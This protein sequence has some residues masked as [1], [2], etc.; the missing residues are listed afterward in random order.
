MSGQGKSSIFWT[1]SLFVLFMLVR[2]ASGEVRI[3]H[4]DASGMR[5]VYEGEEPT[6]R[7]VRWAEGT[8][9]IL[10]IAG[11][12]NGAAPGEPALPTRS[13]LLGVP[14][15]GRVE[16]LVTE[17]QA[18]DWVLPEVAPVP[19]MTWNEEGWYEEQF[20]KDEEIYSR[21]AWIPDQVVR[22]ERDGFLRDQRVVTVTFRP[23][24]YNPIRGEARVYRRI[25]AEVRF[26]DERGAVGRA[27]SLGTAPARFERTEDLYRATLLNYEQARSWRRTGTRQAKRARLE[28]PFAPG[29]WFR[30]AVKSDGMYRITGEDL[31]DA[32]ATL[33]DIVPDE[34]RM[35]YG[36]GEELPL[37]VTASRPERMEEMASLVEDGGDGRFDAED[38]IA[39]WG[40]GPSRWD[41]DGAEEAFRYRLN[42]YTH[43]NI[44]WI[45]FGGDLG[46]RMTGRH[47]SSG[48]GEPVRPW[49]F[50]DR[51]HEE[52]EKQ[53]QSTG[54]VKDSGT[55][56]YWEDKV[57]RRYSFLVHSPDEM[58]TTVVRIHMLGLSVDIHRFAIS[59]NDVEIGTAQFAGKEKTGRTMI[60]KYPGGLKDG[61]NLL[62][63]QQEDD[64]P[65]RLDWYEIEY[66]RRL[67]AE[68]GALRF[69]APTRSGNSM[70]RILGVTDPSFDLL[71]V[72]DPLNVVRIVDAVYDDVE[73]TIAF[74]DNMDSVTPREYHLGYRSGWKRPERIWLDT[75]SDLRGGA[76]GAEYVVIAHEEFID[77]ARRLAEWRAQ[78]DRFGPPMKTAVVDVQDI[79]DEFAWGMFDPTAIRDF[80]K[81]TVEN[82]F[83][84]PYLVVL[85]GGGCFDY[86][87]NYGMSPPN[88]IPPYEADDLTYDE[89]YARVVGEDD[90][91]DLAIGR[92]P[93][94][95][96]E[97][98]QLVVDRLIAY[99]RAPERGSWQNRVL[100]VADDEKRSG[101]APIE[102]EFTRD[103]EDLAIRFIPER[104]DQSK[105]YL[106][107]YD[108]IG[109]FKPDAHD[110]FVR[111]F[112][113]GVVFASYIGH[114]NKDVMAHEHVFVGS[115]DMPLLHN[116]RRLPL[117][118]TAACAVGQ[119]DHPVD[120]SLA[121]LMMK[122]P[123]GGTIAMIGSTR[124]A[125]HGRSMALKRRF[126]DHLF[127]SEQQPAQIGVALWKAKAELNGWWTIYV[128]QCYTLFGDPA[129]RLA[130]P[131]REV[132]LSA[133][134]TLKALD[135]VRIS[136][137]VLEAGTSPF[138]GEVMFRAFDSATT[139]RR[140]VDSGER[141]EYALPGAPIFRGTF[142]IR[143]GQ[144]EGAFVVPKDITYGGRLGRLSAFVWNDRSSG[145]GE[146]EPLMV[147]GTA[148]APQEDLTG[149]RIEIGF[150]GQTFSDGDYVGASPVL[151]LSL[152]DE[153]GINVTGE[154]GHEITVKI[155]QGMESE[156]QMTQTFRVTEHFVAED[157]HQLGRLRYA[158]PELE[159]GD[160]V[161]QVKA[162]DTFNNSSKKLVGIRVAEE[163]RFALSDVLC[164]PN[165]MEDETTFTYRLSR[166][167]E[168]VEIRIFTLSG[169]TVD[170]LTVEGVQGYNQVHWMP[171]ETLANGP[172]LYRIVVQ[173]E[174]GQQTEISE[175]IV[176]MR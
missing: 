80:L 88:R 104:L 89:W 120:V 92:L 175:R 138:D 33:S 24:Q 154:I 159:A 19:R 130:L 46:K 157:G 30:V 79:Y 148:S 86:K 164:H 109:R 139:V 156:S 76:G 125:Y 94:R 64:T 60:L 168:S 78:D 66:S 116:G 158:I 115:S 72:S 74:E 32:G 48:E 45:T 83:P 51:V 111:Q 153:S 140:T 117:L 13:V 124:L 165:P 144:F 167:A 31:Q 22:I 23:V 55:E 95:T 126:C 149:P 61:L 169:R 12:E 6:R 97:E 18:E 82:W 44:Y 166:P 114:S 152:E 110:E 128:T 34:I 150:E 63:I 119:F 37:S 62:G 102:P 75:P 29:V 73:K 67:E 136:G 151:L 129:T 118:Y 173:G 160:Y 170:R 8:A 96:R 121:E 16:I 25:V 134:D 21:D 68:G 38:H 127:F 135:R 93:V 103:E 36:G 54:Y 26:L 49:T 106:M 47:S 174:E 42:P 5:L 59:L 9:E 56:W 2:V 7:H 58:D 131:E 39:F 113:E 3:L 101:K 98:A 27:K 105:V 155:D 11:C 20:L 53:P 77:E 52:A 137:T 50:R 163:E 65:V 147:G 69:A 123:E 87:N 142:P 84:A 10:E 112:N 172:Y 28:S 122:H 171:R 162:W 41:Y 85:M 145:S 57:S 90:L 146:Q 141:V 176:V 35:F 91:P 107:E 43:E 71:E 99:D 81:Y 17:V 4:A 70:F 132:E 161:L 40:Q 108:L 14:T 1:A 133:V 15:E 100:F 143:A